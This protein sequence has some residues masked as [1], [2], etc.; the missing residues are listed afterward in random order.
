[1]LTVLP[2]CKAKEYIPNRN[3]FDQGATEEGGVARGGKFEWHFHGN[4]W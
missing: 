1:M 3:P 2:G 4:D